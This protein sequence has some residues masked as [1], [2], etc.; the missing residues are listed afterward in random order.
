MRVRAATPAL[1]ATLALA[2]TPDPPL[3]ADRTYFKNLLVDYTKTQF[4]LSWSYADIFEGEQKLI[5]G[6]YTRMGVPRE[7]RRYEAVANTKK[8]STLFDNVRSARDRPEIARR[9]CAPRP[10]SHTHDYRSTSTSTT[11]RTRR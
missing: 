11:R 6:D 9:D 4:H 5:Y 10:P 1:A 8:L 7:E 3:H 2:A